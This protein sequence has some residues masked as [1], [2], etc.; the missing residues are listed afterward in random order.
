MS[1]PINIATEDELSEAVLL[2]LLAH[3]NREY[4]VGVAYRR[5]GNGYLKKRAM[6]GTMR[7]GVGHSPY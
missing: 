3:V 7:P 6:A 2:E 1:I 5:F 4:V